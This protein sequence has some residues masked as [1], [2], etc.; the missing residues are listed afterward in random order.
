MYIFSNLQVRFLIGKQIVY[1]F[2]ENFIVTALDK[3]FILFLFFKLD[4]QFF[5]GALH[6][7]TMLVHG[8]KLLTGH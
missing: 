4:K 5:Q 6:D 3:V 1:M 8:F 7:S 2:V